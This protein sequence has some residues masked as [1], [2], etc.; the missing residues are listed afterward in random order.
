MLL[1]TPFNKYRLGLVLAPF[2]APARAHLSRLRFVAAIVAPV[3]AAA[4]AVVALLLFVLVFDHCVSMYA[5]LLLL[6]VAGG[7]VVVDCVVC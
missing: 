6:S 3:V 2:V 5:L 4:V 7:A 1:L